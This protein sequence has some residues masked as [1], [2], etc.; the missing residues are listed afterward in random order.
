MP[1]S[2]RVLKISSLASSMCAARF[3]YHLAEIGKRQNPSTDDKEQVSNIF[4][5][6]VIKKR[7][8]K[9]MLSGSPH[10]DGRAFNL[11]G[12]DECL[13]RKVELSTF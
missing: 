11:P 2:G 7:A 8:I 6:V 13:V 4:V 12:A 9:A 10:F 1:F 5:T 3:N